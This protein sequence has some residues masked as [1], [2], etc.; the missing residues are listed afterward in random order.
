MGDTS[1]RDATIRRLIRWAAPQDAVRALLLTSTRAVP[2]AAVDALSDYDV[3]LVARD[4]RPFAA[5]RDWV[6]DFGAV[7]VDHWNPIR[8]DPA[9]GFAVA[10][11]VVQY[12]DGP[13]IDFTLWPVALLAQLACAPALPDELDGGYRILLDKDGT[14]ARLRPPTYRAHI[15]A[16]PAAEE[17]QALVREFFN[18][19]PYV[20][21]YLW[22]GELLPAKWGLDHN[23]TYL[24]TADARVAHGAR[25]RLGGAR[26]HPGQGP[27][28]PPPGGP[29]RA[30]RG[31]LRGGRARGELGGALRDASPLP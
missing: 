13:K 20:A 24:P 27:G 22:R 11:N 1:E 6:A 15:P 28:A 21:K 25:S 26:P 7:L 2:G 16:K 8:P 12:A 29:P 14:A 23:I 3:I 10:G 5:E 4:I 30:A 17:Y 9:T 18:D 31:Y 19:A